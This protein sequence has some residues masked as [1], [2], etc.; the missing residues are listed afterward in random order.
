MSI[1]A[2]RMLSPIG[3]DIGATD[4]RVVQLI[5]DPIGCACRGVLQGHAGAP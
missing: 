4:L 5:G 1:E 3:V 2:D